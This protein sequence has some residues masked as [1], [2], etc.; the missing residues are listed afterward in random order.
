MLIEF[1]NNIEFEDGAKKAILNWRKILLRLCEIK[2]KLE[3]IKRRDN[4]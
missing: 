3:S 2:D 4:A 1:G